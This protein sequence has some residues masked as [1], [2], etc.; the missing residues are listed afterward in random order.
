MIIKVQGK[1]MKVGT[2]LQEKVEGKLAKFHRFFDDETTATVKMQP[3]KN[4]I[5]VEL[6]LNLNGQYTRAEAIGGEAILALEDAID[7]M[8][9]QIRK[10][11]TKIKK[12]S[13][14]KPISLYLDEMA[15]DDAIDAPASEEPQIIRRKS[16]LISPMDADEA[17][18]QMELLGHDFLL[19]VD[20]E[21]EKV[22]LV[23][24][25][26]DGNYGLI[27]PEY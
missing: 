9:R 8:E 14:S 19:Y 23:Y 7:N 12:K 17:V 4:D 10:H 3:E 13:K 6:T 1:G 15:F 22:C 21:T 5:R 26:N 24:K 16:F 25:R 2:G 18:L 20:A 11:K 27:E